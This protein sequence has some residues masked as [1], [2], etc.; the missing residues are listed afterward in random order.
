MFYTSRY[1]S[2]LGAIILESNGKELVGLRFN[3]KN[4]VDDILIEQGGEIKLPIFKQTKRWLDIYFSGHNPDFSLPLNMDGIS[5][6]RKRVWEIMLAIPF[7]QLSTY[8]K[9]AKQIELETGKKISAQAVGGAI[10][11]NSI[12]II[13]PC[14]RVVGA[15]NSF[16]GYAW[17]IEKKKELLKLEGIDISKF[18]VPENVQ[19][20]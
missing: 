7:G 5:S 1:N 3:K 8:G 9:I 2:P 15:N 14:H 17:G 4:N 6:F 11:H 18:S 20:L 13:I 12:A 16:V 19:R 10:S